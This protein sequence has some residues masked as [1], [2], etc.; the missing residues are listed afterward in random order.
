L[1]TMGGTFSGEAKLGAHEPFPLEARIHLAADATLRNARA[2]F[3]AS[4][5]LTAVTVD[6]T[7]TANEG[8]ATAHVALAAFRGVPLVSVAVGARDVDLSAW[9]PALPSTR[10]AGTVDAKPANGGLAGSLDFANTLTGSFDSGRTPIR[11]LAAR[12][13]WTSEAL[14]LDSI[15]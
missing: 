12:F 5:T 1:V 15:D 9:D 7:A 6:A 3:V 14:T 13:A 10:I 2:D 11:A 8:R 4:G